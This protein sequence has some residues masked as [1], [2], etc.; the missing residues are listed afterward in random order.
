MVLQS[1][2]PQ[3]SV[4]PRSQCEQGARQPLHDAAGEQTPVRSPRASGVTLGLEKQSAETG[5]QVS[6]A[7]AF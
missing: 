4:S 7:L 6:G 5:R 3:R 1:L 2:V